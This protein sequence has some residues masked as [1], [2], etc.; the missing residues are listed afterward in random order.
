MSYP[1]AVMICTMSK[2]PEEDYDEV[3]METPPCSVDNGA[4]GSCKGTLSK[5]VSI[6]EKSE[7]CYDKKMNPFVKMVLMSVALTNIWIVNGLAV[8]LMLLNICTM[9]VNIHLSAYC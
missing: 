2:A 3:F 4:N 5:P 7:Y 1:F 8:S 9:S 6:Y